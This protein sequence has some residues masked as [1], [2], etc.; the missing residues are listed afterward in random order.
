MEG[1]KIGRVQWEKLYQNKEE[2]G[3]GIKDIKMF[4]TTLLDKWK[5][6]LG[7]KKIGL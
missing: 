1:R 7:T 5:W 3:S 2:G 6:R 4:N